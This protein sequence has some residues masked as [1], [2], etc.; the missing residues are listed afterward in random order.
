MSHSSFNW[1][2]VWR[3]C[4]QLFQVLLKASQNN[5][6]NSRLRAPKQAH[7][8]INMLGP[9]TSS[10]RRL[11]FAPLQSLRQVSLRCRVSAVQEADV[12][13]NVLHAV[14]VH[15]E[16]GTCHPPRSR[17]AAAAQ[18]SPACCGP[19]SSDLWARG[20]NPRALRTLGRL[21]ENVI[22]LGFR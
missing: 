1:V 16:N 19:G 13:I 20:H 2:T 7:I 5:A 21:R 4:P 11:G 14:V 22:P 12:H 6:T 15:L 17:R 18:F 10:T 3:Q 8:L 9:A